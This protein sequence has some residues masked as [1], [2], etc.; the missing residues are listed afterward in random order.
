MAVTY[1]YLAQ[2]LG[3]SPSVIS[4]VLN[5]KEY[6]RVSPKRRQEILDLAQK[7]DCAPNYAALALKSGR[8]GLIGVMMNAPVVACYARMATYLQ[9]RLQ[10]MG[11]TALF[12]FW[13]K[14]SSA[15][16]G[17]ISAAYSNLVRHGVE[18][19]ILWNNQETPFPPPVPTVMYSP[20]RQDYPGDSLLFDN[21]LLVESLRRH[22]GS[23]PMG[24]ILSEGDGR[25]E[26]LLKA[27]LVRR[28]HLLLMMGDDTCAGEK[29]FQRFQQLADIPKYWFFSNQENLQLF[30]MEA[31]KRHYCLE[32]DFEAVCFEDTP[33]FL[34]SIITVHYFRSFRR[35]TT[36]MLVDLLMKRIEDPAAPVRQT[37]ICPEPDFR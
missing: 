35:N 5:G 14:E 9:Q 31:V 7:L 6:C 10:K 8:S 11:K 27:G 3:V 16:K 2:R 24:A 12:Y 23:A 13:D 1:K 28:E 33:F 21:S 36:D 29:I 19:I 20:D 34:P 25:I 17:A 32:H 30:A 26:P 37:Y 4:A 15:Q 22:C 18:G